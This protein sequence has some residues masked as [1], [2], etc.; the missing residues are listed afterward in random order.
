MAIDYNDGDKKVTNTQKMELTIKLAGEAMENGELPISAIIF[1]DDEIVTTAYTTDKK[2][3]SYIM[4]AEIKALQQADKM[5][6]TFKEQNKM[7]LFTT[8]EPCLMCMGASMSFY[9]GEIFYS[10][11]APNDGAVELVKNWNRDKTHLQAYNVPK[12]NKGL[13]RE[14]VK[15]MFKD[16]SDN[17]SGKMSEWALYQSQI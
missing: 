16:Y 17:N 7:Q 4:H 1:L 11:E 9:I 2:D 13:M 15:K 12:I 3:K 8:L 14:K 10:L 6:F 5:G